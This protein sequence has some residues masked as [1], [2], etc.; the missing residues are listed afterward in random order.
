M[1]LIGILIIS[2]I[3]LA[4]AFSAI[5]QL[6]YKKMGLDFKSILKGIFERAF[7]VITLYF[8]YPHA[9]TFFS[10]VK[11]GTRLK[12]EEKQEEDQNRFNDFY[13]FGNFISVIFAILYVQLLNNFYP[14]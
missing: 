12:H 8:G 9:L 1:I 7:L 3:V 10:A 11:L 6:F 14:R 5:A 4:F 13:L 2:E